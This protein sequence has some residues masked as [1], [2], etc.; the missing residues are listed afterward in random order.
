MLINTDLSTDTLALSLQQK[1]TEAAAATSQGAAAPQAAATASQVDPLLQRLT[2]GPSSLQ[3]GELDVH[4]ESEAM[5]GMDSLL[6]SM[7]AQPGTAM[8]A[9]ANQLSENVLSL[10]QPTD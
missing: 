1:R 3:D 9:Q 5:Q 4:N 6:H 2:D 8:A 7:R 10:L